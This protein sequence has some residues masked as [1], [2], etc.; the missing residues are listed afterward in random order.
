MKHQRMKT[1]RCILPPFA[2][3]H[4]CFL[5]FIAWIIND[6]IDEWSYRGYHP[7]TIRN[8]YLWATLTVQCILNMV[9]QYKQLSTEMTLVSS[10]S[11]TVQT[12]CWMVALSICLSSLHTSCTFFLIVFGVFIRPRFMYTW[13]CGLFIGLYAYQMIHH[14]AHKLMLRCQAT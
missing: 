11:I 14:A 2:P 7:I 1:I 12:R 8:P 3:L 13:L 4:V 9:R 10:S 5:L 6:M